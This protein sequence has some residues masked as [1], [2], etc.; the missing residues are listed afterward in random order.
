M[1]PDG[2]ESVDP[3]IRPLIGRGTAL[4]LV[5]GTVGLV[6]VYFATRRLDPADPSV[7]GIRTVFDF[8]NEG[9]VPTWWNASL[10]AAVAAVLLGAAGLATEGSP[11]SRRSLVI[12]GLTTS[13]CG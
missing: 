12:A 8:D 9:T 3:L 1:G 13:S 2:G 10:L 6:A 7:A 4:T 5:G 11:P